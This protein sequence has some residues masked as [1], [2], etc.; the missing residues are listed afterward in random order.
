VDDARP[1]SR[2][3]EQWGKYLTGDVPRFEAFARNS[4]STSCL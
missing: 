1:F 2:Y 3:M 4:V